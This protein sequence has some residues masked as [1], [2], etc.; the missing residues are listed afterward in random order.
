[1]AKA[2]RCFP[3]GPRKA[4][5]YKIR[6]YGLNG[7]VGANLVFAHFRLYVQNRSANGKQKN[8]NSL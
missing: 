1:M 5:E 7:S 3:T 4:G 6:P 2:S 8:N